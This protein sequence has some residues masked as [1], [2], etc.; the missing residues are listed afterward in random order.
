[1]E[2]IV[3][4]VLQQDPIIL[5]Q[6]DVLE[7]RK[8]KLEHATKEKVPKYSTTLF[9]Q[10]PMDGYNQKD[11]LF[12]M[13]RES[14]SYEKHPKHKALYDAFVQS[15]LVDENDMDRSVVEPPTQKRRRHDDEG[16]D[17][18]PDFEKEQKKRRRKDVEPPKKSSTS[19]ESS[20]GKTPPKTSKTG[21]SITAEESVVEPVH[22]ATMDVEEPIQD[23]VVNDANQPQDKNVDDGPEQTWFNDMVNVE[24]DSLTFDEL[25]ATP[26]D[27]TKFAMNCL[28][29]KKI[30]KTNPEGDRCPYDLSKPLPL[31]GSS[32][33]LTIHVDFFLNN[34]LEYLKIE[35][36]KRKYTASIAKIKV[37]KYKLKFD[38]EM[39]PKLWSP[40]KV[41]YDRNAKLGISH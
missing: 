37:V 36:S 31:Q 21:K 8:I 28:K 2:S 7:I 32:G 34:D 10:A 39:I 3:R 17:P 26:I 25:M 33:H 22:K 40:V 16:Q 6:K 12:K 38:E 1:M 19:K 23:D 20:K 13:M 11:I 15:L 5:K 41:A 18:P 29:L 9:D 27:F 35:N 4:D 14:K 24:K 30:T